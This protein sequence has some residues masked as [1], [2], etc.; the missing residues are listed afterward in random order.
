MFVNPVMRTTDAIYD[1]PLAKAVQEIQEKEPGIWIGADM[2]SNF[3]IANGAPTIT[4]TNIFPA[5]ER[6]EM[7]DENGEKQDIYN[8]YAHI[9]LY[10]TEGETELGPG[11]SGDTFSLYLNPNDLYRLGVNYICASPGHVIPMENFGGSLT[12]LYEDQKMCIRDRD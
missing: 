2:T 9:F 1:K 10:F 3:L 7:F 12:V 11:P 5:L 6:W 4:S 8:R